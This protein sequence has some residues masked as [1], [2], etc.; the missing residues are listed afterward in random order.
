MD[1]AM[2]VQHIHSGT[3]QFAITAEFAWF[4]T[5]LPSSE[6]QLSHHKDTPHICSNTRCALAASAVQGGYKV[7][8]LFTVEW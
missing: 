8:L 1:T 3:A 6:A 2:V 4:P 7:P 5:V